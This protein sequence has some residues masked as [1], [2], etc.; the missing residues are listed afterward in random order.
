MTA[1]DAEVDVLVIGAGGAG[2]AAAVAAHEAGA[3]VAIVE[4]LDRPGGNTMLSTG[5]IPG[6]GTR[7]QAA[8]GID[9]DAQRMTRDLMALSG[10]HDADALTRQLCACSAELVEWLADVMQ[11]RLDVIRDYRHVAHSVPR[12]HAPASRKGQDLVDD[13]VA[14]VQRRGIP[15]ALGNAAI[16]LDADAAGAVQ[17]ASTR[18]ATGEAARIGAR[19]TILCVNGFGADAAL[20]RRH[21]PE[22]AGA[23]YSGAKGSEGEAVR[24]GEQLGAALGNMASYQGYASVL[25]P[26]GELLSWTTI[27]KGGVFVNAQGRRFGDES[28]GYSGYAAAVL[29]QQGPV[30]ALF[31]QRIHDIAAREPWFKEVLDYG[32]ARHAAD[33]PALARALGVDAAALAETLSVYEAAAAGQRPDPH[34]RKDFGIAPLQP[35]YWYARVVPALLST[36]GGLMIDADARVLGGGGAPI[37]NLYAAGGAVAGISGRS[38]GVGYASGSGL[39]HAI[40]LGWIAGR[41]SARHLSA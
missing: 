8:A 7:F 28:V 10:P 23:T 21:C 16:E 27:E 6:A 25:D 41:A 33:V 35:G 20:V 37:A 24:W 19:K 36:Q 22:I 4:K 30:H 5:S 34:G 15:L 17:G 29:D 3:S 11:V 31:D 14:A 2:L 40:G 13:M 12:L 39:L 38:G 32:G 26:H 1:F 9:D 18:S